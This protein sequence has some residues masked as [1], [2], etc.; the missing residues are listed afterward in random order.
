MFTIRRFG[1]RY[2]LIGLRSS[3]IRWGRRIGM[4]RSSIGI[5]EGTLG[6]LRTRMG[7]CSST[8]YL[9]VKTAWERLEAYIKT[10]WGEDRAR[11]FMD[12]LH[13]SGVQTHVAFHTPGVSQF[14]V[15]IPGIASIEGDRTPWRD[16]T[17]EVLIDTHDITNTIRVLEEAVK[18][19]VRNQVV[20]SENEARLAKN[21]EAH[22]ALIE[23]LRELVRT[24]VR[25]R[26]RRLME[27]PTQ[28]SQPHQ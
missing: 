2:R 11:L 28:P 18:A 13:K 3:G 10:S 12:S 21:M 7:R 15:K 23:E 6:L 26:V 5:Q 22:L 1:R 27:Q 24:L 14:R 9:N 8:P 25:P 17:S 16:G 19:I 4:V 20:F